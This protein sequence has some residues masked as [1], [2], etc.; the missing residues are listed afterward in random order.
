VSAPIVRA[1]RRSC[2]FGDIDALGVLDI[3]N[4][5]DAPLPLMIN[6]TGAVKLRLKPLV[7]P[8]DLDEAA[9]KTPSYRPPGQ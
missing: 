5:A 7:S 9:R 8:E 1:A 3:P 4:E 6:S 2:A